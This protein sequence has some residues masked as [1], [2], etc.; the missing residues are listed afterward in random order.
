VSPTDV[1]YTRAE[2]DQVVEKFENQYFSDNSTK[3]DIP[4]FNY[5]DEYYGNCPTFAFPLKKGEKIK[6]Y[7][8]S[9]YQIR[10]ANDIKDVEVVSPTSYHSSTYVNPIRYWQPSV[11]TDAHVNKN[12]ELAKVISIADDASGYYRDDIQGE[13]TIGSLMNKSVVIEAVE[14]CIVLIRDIGAQITNTIFGALTEVNKAAL[15]FKLLVEEISYTIEQ[16][17][18]TV[19]VIG[20]FI[21]AFVATMFWARYKL[22]STINVIAR[23]ASGNYHY[24][25]DRLENENGHYIANYNYLLPEVE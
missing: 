11:T 13:I 9:N 3:A 20:A 2:I 23:I 1:I 12:T 17:T 15:T 16:T 5:E 19:Q 7:C 6:L 10:A 14:E 8:N 22:Q 24:W 18:Y 25:W 21:P 4:S